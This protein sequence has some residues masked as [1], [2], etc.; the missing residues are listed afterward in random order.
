MA[1]GPCTFRQ[2]D[3]TAAVKAVAAAGMEVARVEIDPT[4]GRIVVTVARASEPAAE[5]VGGNE[6]DAVTQERQ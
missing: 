2:R 4:T 6:W 5:S 3:M 1:R